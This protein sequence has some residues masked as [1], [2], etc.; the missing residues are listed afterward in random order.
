MSAAR[1]LATGLLAG[2]AW[3][4]IELDRRRADLGWDRDTA[5]GQ[6]SVATAVVASLG[7]LRALVLD[8]L[9]CQ[10]T[11]QWMRKEWHKSAATYELI[12]LVS[13]HAPEVAV[14]H[15]WTM[16]YDIAGQ[17]VARGDPAAARGWLARGLALLEDARRRHPESAALVHALSFVHYD[18]GRTEPYRSLFLS[19]GTDPLERARELAREAAALAPA[20]PMHRYWL[21]LACRHVALAHEAAGRWDPAL[22]ALAESRDA[23]ARTRALLPPPSDD[24]PSLGFMHHR[25]RE[26]AQLT[27]ELE[28]RIRDRRTAERA[29]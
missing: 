12:E 5:T 21:S 19:R 1:L 23:L 25:A 28:R 24:D 6:G 27:S 22:A 2:S 17:A 13:G 14:A 16:C 3:C 4:G 15:A 20:A 8:L 29:R 9:W 7:G 11:D 26:V 18:K 10:A